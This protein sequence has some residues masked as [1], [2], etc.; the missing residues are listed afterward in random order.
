MS[1]HPILVTGAAGFIGFHVARE[2]LDAGRDVVGFD[3]I[4]DYY[5]PK[6]KRARLAILRA[7]PR[8]SFVHADL[9]DRAAVAALFSEN[10]FEAVIHLAAQAGV[11]YSIGNPHAY[12]DANL[13][14][15]VNV[16]EGCRHNGCRHLVYASSSSVYGANTKLPF[17]VADRTDHPISLYAATK[18][19]N[20]VMAHSYSHLYR[21]P[22]TGLR[23]FTIYGPWYRPDMALFLFANAIVAGAPIKLFNHGKM[24]R[25]FTYIADVTRVV[26]RLIE[27]VPDAGAGA[28]PARIYNVGNHRPEEL[29]RVVGLL[30]QELGRAAVKEMLPMQPGDV[31]ATFADIDD[32]VRDVG[33]KPETAIEDGIRSFVAWYREHYGV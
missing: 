5:D 15:F 2:L 10:R 9:A 25:D 16:L 17:S 28:A 30:E 8:F 4:N 26:L 7:N 3:N 20:E 33:F 6:L 22:T 11:R 29:M 21:L 12:A 31:P 19:A 18:K 13:E 23:F 1:N 24:R 14:G 32:L 27:R